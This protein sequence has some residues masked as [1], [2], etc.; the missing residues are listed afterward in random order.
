MTAHFD[1]TACPKLPGERGM[2]EKRIELFWR[3]FL[4]E[5]FQVG[6]RARSTQPPPPP[7]QEATALRTSPAPSGFPRS[8]DLVVARPIRL[9]W[10]AV[11]TEEKVRHACQLFGGKLEGRRHP[12][13]GGRRDR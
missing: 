7:F 11:F 1:A 12:V 9:E 13:E 10:D 2:A 8:Q 3:V 6:W 4:D 5:D